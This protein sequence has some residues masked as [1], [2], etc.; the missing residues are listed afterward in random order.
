[1]AYIEFLPRLMAV[2]F[3][4]LSAKV[5][6]FTLLIFISSLIW[7]DGFPN[8][9]VAVALAMASGDIQTQ[10]GD[11]NAMVILLRAGNLAGV[12]ISV[13]ASET[14]IG[15]PKGAPWWGRLLGNV[16]VSFAIGF[17]SGMGA[18]L[19]IKL[20]KNANEG[21][22]K[23]EAVR[24]MLVSSAGAICLAYLFAESL[25]FSSGLISIIVCGFTMSLYK[26]TTN[27]ERGRATEL[28]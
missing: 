7:L 21:I 28:I 11:E 25:S 13:I 14:L 8:S 12:T 15:P 17:L 9:V 16:L 20:L 3:L 5:G 6:T 2:Y 27:D 26:S 22:D 18:L 19:G 1:M 23:T 24:L 10:E 4:K